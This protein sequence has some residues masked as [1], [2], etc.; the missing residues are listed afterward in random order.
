MNIPVRL[1]I[2][3][4]LSLLPPLSG[5]AM[6]QVKPHIVIFI[7]DDHGQLDSEPYGATDVQTPNMKRL[8][9]AGMTFSHAFAASPSCAPSRASILTGLMPNRHGAMVNH[10]APRDDVRKWPHFLRMLGYLCAAFGKVAHYNQDKHYGFDHHDRVHDAKTVAAYLD[11]RDK[12]KPMCLFVGTHSPHVPWPMETTY[13]PAKLKVP[14]SHVDTKE[15]REMRARYYAAISKADRDLGDIIDL[16]RAR[17]GENVLFIYMSDHGAQWPFGK[18]NLYDAGLRVPFLA[19]W[20]GVITPASRS[21]AMISLVDLLPTMIEV[22]GGRAPADLD[23][24]S[25]LDVLRG[26]KANHR[27]RIFA[28]HS[29]DGNMNVY[30]IRAVRTREW[31]YLRNLDSQATQTTHIDKAMGKDGLYYWLSWAEKSKADPAA[32]RIVER[33]QK[34]P[35]EELYDLKADPFQLRNLA[36]EPAHAERIRQLRA[37]LDAWMTQQKDDG[38]ATEKKQVLPGKKKTE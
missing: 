6:A 2:A 13:E 20:P 8:A 1:F 22:G 29:R 7:S 31:S 10:A 14:A 19:A 5:Q 38:L 12:T 30:P 34:R 18:W 9:K 24:Q 17:L 3:S 26:K 35:V 21:D 25:F 4:M 23:G 27:D 16:V 32:A 11:A 37:E 33:Y 28:T 36:T 15:T